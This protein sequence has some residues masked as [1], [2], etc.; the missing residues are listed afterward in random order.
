MTKTTE[1]PSLE[2]LRLRIEAT[3]DSALPN[4]SPLSQQLVAAMRYAVQGGGKRIRP[5]LTCCA[6]EALTGDATPALAPAAAVELVHAYSLVHDDL[7]AMD[8]DVL[9]RGRPTCH[10]AFGQATA[11]LAGDALLTLAFDVLAAADLIDPAVRM[12]MVHVLACAA[13]WGGMVGGQALDIGSTGRALDSATLERMHRGKTGALVTVAV[14]L[15]AL[16]A[17][18]T[19][20]QYQALSRFGEHVGLAFQMIDDVLDTTATSDDLGK[21]VGADAKAYK[22]TFASLLGVQSTREHA[23]R[24]LA[25]AFTELDRAGIEGSLK[26]LAE[27]AVRRSH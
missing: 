25:D 11:I 23:E 19:E 13:G 2:R 20:S 22:T 14:Q 16:A 9:R 17:G 7:P 27:Y 4:D 21:S 6:C 12:R 1:P 8:D 5:L 24:L 10:I 26:A 15:G 18:A 3:L